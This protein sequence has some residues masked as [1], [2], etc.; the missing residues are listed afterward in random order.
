MFDRSIDLLRLQIE[1]KIL[2]QIQ[3]FAYLI[4]NFTQISGS[5]EKPI[6]VILH[7]PRLNLMVL[8][9]SFALFLE[10]EL[11]SLK[12]H[13]AILLDSAGLGR[14]ERARKQQRSY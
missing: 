5:E 1:N 2:G 12:M 4:Y 13:F 10:A 11:F 3:P 9:H 6:D 7:S 14:S 8:K